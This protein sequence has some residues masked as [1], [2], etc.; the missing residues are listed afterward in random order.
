VEGAV[1]H[2]VE[3]WALRRAAADGTPPPALV[4]AVHAA[5][6]RHQRSLAELADVAAA[7]RAAGVRYLVAKGPVLASVYHPA[8][9][10]RSYHD[11]DILVAPADLPGAVAALE[12]SGF[13]TLDANWSLLRRAEVHELKMRGPAGGV[14]DLHWSLGLRGGAVDL[15]WSLG[16]GGRRPDHS[17]PAEALLERAVEEQIASSAHPVPE[18]ADMAVHVALHA[19]RSGGKRLVWLADLR[20][21]L[22]GAPPGR[23]TG[24]VVER[25]RDWGAGPALTVM[26]AR[27]V[28][29]LGWPSSDGT[30][31][32]ATRTSWGRAARGVQHRWPVARCA[33]GRSPAGL[34]ARSSRTTPLRSW[35]A[36][37]QEAAAAAAHA[38]RHGVS[39]PTVTDCFADPR[40]ALYEAGGPGEK[41]AFLDG[42]AHRATGP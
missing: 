35:A 31:E 25:A 24:E 12:R 16:R 27:L 2:G 42:V 22:G 4:L 32:A 39:P 30:L 20:A 5:L 17:P 38:L 18:W 10:L 34:L 8:P 21:V 36:L 33:S 7:L 15:Q 40:S 29:T 26:A 14:V 23:D 3:G 41:R 9:D 13:R 19:A 11:L 1:W 37:P 28:A 6:A